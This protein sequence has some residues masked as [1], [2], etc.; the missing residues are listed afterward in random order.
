MALA[1]SLGATG[2]VAL[3]QE[4]TLHVLLAAGQDAPTP[5]EIVEGYDFSS[6]GPPPLSA[7]VAHPPEDAEYLLP[8]RASGAFKAYLAAH[9]D[10]A[11]A[12][13]ERYIVVR[14]P[15][16]ANLTAAR[17]AL[18]ADDNVEFAHSVAPAEFTVA[19]SLTTRALQSILPAQAASDWRTPLHVDEA[20]ATAGG[21]SLVGTVDSGIATL[22]SALRAFHEGKYAGGNYLSA[23]SYDIGRTGIGQCE[24]VADCIER[25][26]DEAQPVPVAVGGNCD[27]DGDGMAA[28]SSAGHGTHVA[29]LIAAR[30]GEVQGVCEHCGIAAWRITREQCFQDGSIVSRLNPTAADAAIT[31]QADIGVQVINQSFGRAS[32]I[33][34]TH[35]QQHPL[36]SECSALR[37]ASDRGVILVAAAGNNRTSIAFPANQPNVVASGGL[38]TD[39]Q[40]WNRDRDLPPNHLDDC[41]QP[42]AVQTLGQECG[43]NFTVNVGTDRRQEVTAPAEAVLSTTYPGLNWNTALGCG[44]GIDGTNGDGVGPCTGTSMAAPIIAGIAGLLRSINPLVLPGDPDNA[45]DAIGVRDVLVAT[46]DAAKSGEP[47]NR[48]L[49]YGRPDVAAAARRMLGTVRGSQVRNRAI[50]LF[51]FHSTAATD[52]ASMA[53]PQAAMTLAVTQ[54]WIWAPRGPLVAG[55]PAY[56]MPPDATMPAPQA[57]AFVLSTEFRTQAQQPPLAPLY[58]LSRSRPWPLGCTPG[59]PGCNHANR[60][61]LLVSTESALETAVADG[62]EFLGRQGYL[63][64][65]CSP[66]PACIPAGATKLHRLCNAAEDD[67]AVFLEHE[68]AT[69]QAAGYT[70]PYPAG[71]DPV[72]GYA[73]RNLDTDGDTL[74][75]GF[76]RL[77][78]TNPAS[79]D[80]D[81]DGSADGVEYPLAGVPVS[82]PC[83]GPAI[84]CTQPGV[85]FDGFE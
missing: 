50:P 8:V 23:L 72:M 35:C 18:L 69:F 43:S 7:F 63:F 33:D 54:P 74:I 25:N 9:S 77:I 2:P 13:L 34:P 81:G 37:H 39:L 24:T 57:S 62:Y 59:T 78:G 65:R 31:I 41:P 14:Y 22:H 84:T 1:V 28:P 56:P 29:G 82:D 36:S 10:S 26:P 83:A 16:G 75:D 30:G 48:H 4:H 58:Q 68:L 61:F 76:E 17:N 52:Y 32:L 71:T 70:A 38:G 21:W 11:R 73:Y 49:G 40:L 47:W 3:A 12:R 60:D 45:V 19:S 51:D 27:A 46:T 55:Y 67:C 53:S 42:P 20:W 6:G 5:Q 44:D 64:Q 85:F 80:S 79:A 66:E 15:S